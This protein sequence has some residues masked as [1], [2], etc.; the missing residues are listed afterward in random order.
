MTKI[1]HIYKDYYPVLGGIEN[2]LRTLAEAQAAQGHSVAVMVTSRTRQTHCSEMNG[3]RIIF[4]GRLATVASTPLS[5]ALPLQLRRERADIV[6]LHFPYPM[7]DLAHRLTGR[8]RRTVITYHSDIVR[9][10]NL[11]RFYAPFLRLALARADRIVATSPGYIETSPFLAPQ[12]AKCV[13]VPYG[14]HPA[15]F[16][17]VDPDRVAALRAPYREPLILFVG[18]LRY[19]KGVEFLIRA[20]PQVLGHL[21]LVGSDTTTRRDE[22]EALAQTLGITARVTFLGEQ[23]ATLPAYFRACDVFA[24]PS[25]ERSEAFGIVQLEAMAAGKPVVSCDVGTGVAWVNQNEITGL[26]VPPR[27]PA[28]LAAALNRLTADASLRAQMGTAGRQRV[29]S[30]FTVD[31]MVDRIDKVYQMALEGSSSSVFEH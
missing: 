17:S 14:I 20:M 6:H 18:Q 27:D 28:A 23:D 24:L 5:L 11:L 4:A 15:R 2:H 8:I 13:V 9:Q 29:Q 7:G 21:W 25:I 22:L 19:Y 1:L 30:E 10:K 26:V 31:K 16:E 3:V 12:A